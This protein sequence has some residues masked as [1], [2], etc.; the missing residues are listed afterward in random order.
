MV[1]RGCLL[2]GLMVVVAGFELAIAQDKKPASDSTSASLDQLSWLVGHW[3]SEE[4]G[5]TVEEM[6]TDGAGGTM[7]GLNRTIQGGQLRE[8][9]FLRIAEKDGRI[10]YLASPGGRFPPT[11]FPLSKIEGTSV[12]FENPQHDFPQRIEY[13][14][15]GETLHAKVSGKMNGKDSTLSWQWKR[16]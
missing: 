10:A 1:K 15:D 16:R 2:T 7:F 6:W 11:V 9:E 8:F 5:K 14:L 4:G 12:V 3:G 13:R